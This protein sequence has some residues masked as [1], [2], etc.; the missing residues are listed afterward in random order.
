MFYDTTKVR[1]SMLPSTKHLRIVKGHLILPILKK[2]NRQAK[3]CGSID[4]EIRYSL[5]HIRRELNYSASEACVWGQIL[6]LQI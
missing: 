1:L 2:K 5:L 3:I 4:V 6:D